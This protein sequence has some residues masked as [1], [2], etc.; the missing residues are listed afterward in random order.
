M[1]F[2]GNC[3]SFSVLSKADN[4]FLFTNN[5]WLV[6]CHA[7][8]WIHDSNH[9]SDK[10][11]IFFLYLTSPRKI[12][13]FQRIQLNWMR[14]TFFV[15]R[16]FIEK[17]CDRERSF[18]SESSPQLVG[19]FYKTNKL[20]KNK[21]KKGRREFGSQHISLWNFVRVSCFQRCWNVAFQHILKIIFFVVKHF[22]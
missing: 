17:G 10:D 18:I 19:I 14:P 16:K 7:H 8:Q 12:S 3:F 15:N 11:F 21:T 2:S 9:G 20:N 22:F 13:I 1:W 6:K 5:E 4:S